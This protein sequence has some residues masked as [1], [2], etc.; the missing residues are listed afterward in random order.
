MQNILAVQ[1]KAVL[2]QPVSLKNDSEPKIKRSLRDLISD[3]VVQELGNK[4]F[5]S[6]GTISNKSIILS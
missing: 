6:K 1:K 4:M 5:P 2:L 3:D